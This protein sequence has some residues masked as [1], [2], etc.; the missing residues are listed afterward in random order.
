[1]F[2]EFKNDKLENHPTIQ[3]FADI[4]NKRY[5]GI[6]LRGGAVVDI[7]EGREPKDYDF[8][9]SGSGDIEAFVQNGFVFKYKTKSSETYEFEAE[10]K[11]TTVQ[12]LSRNESDFD[13][14]I[15]KSCYDFKKKITL[16]DTDAF[17]NKILIPITFEHVSNALNS[18]RRIVHWRKKGYKI[19]DKTYLSLLNVVGQS[20]EFES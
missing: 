5:S 3:W 2:T 13:F 20:E 15:S 18:L 14:T 16:V 10:G 12:F 6:R 19:H 11:T 17:N 1:M 9:N 7:L 8:T 4:L